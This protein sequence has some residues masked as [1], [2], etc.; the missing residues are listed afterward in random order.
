MRFNFRS[1][2]IALTASAALFVGACTK[3]S[4]SEA[5]PVKPT[6]VLVHGAFAESASWDGVIPLLTSDGYRV[7]AAANP[8][9]SVASD[10]ADISSLVAT[11]EGPVVL[12]G[13]SYGGTVITQAAAPNKN[14][15]AL[16][17][18]SAFT[19][20]VGE[21]SG[22]L[23]EHDPGATLAAAL[24]PPVKLADGSNDLSVD[25][26]K[27]HAQFAADVPAQKAAL[28][29]ATQRPIRDAALGEAVKAAAWKTIPSYSIYGSADFNIPPATMAFM[30]Q[31]A[32]SRRTIVIEGGSHVVMISHPDQVAALIKEAATAP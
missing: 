2:L 20:D 29:A 18:V 30:A 9:R 31:R 19:P 1:A 15:R 4:T 32:K 6:I 14:V 5:A 28:M 17:Y 26:A 3:S 11:I 7:I 12:V 22:K 21:S 27:F 16:V 13:H 8:L 23:S 10:A 25:V 24:A